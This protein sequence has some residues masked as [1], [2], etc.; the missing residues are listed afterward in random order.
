VPDDLLEGF[1]RD[2]GHSAVLLDIDGTLAPI[3]LHPDDASVPAETIEVLTRLVGRFAL[4]ACVS[5]RPAAEAQRLVPVPGIAFSGNHGLEIA[6]GDA[7]LTVPDAEPYVPTMAALV[8]RLA[9]VAAATGAWIE[10]KGVT[11]AVHYRQ[12]PDPE[13]AEAYLRVEALPLVAEHGLS[14]RFGRMVLEVRPPVPIDKGTA[15]RRLLHGRRIVRSLFAG[16]DTTDLDA[17][18]EV[19]VAIAVVSPEAPP[20]LADAAP[21]VVDGPLGAREL[22]ASLLDEE[23]ARAPQAV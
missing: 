9:P 16:D 7:I 1:R 12:A 19:D 15:V 6:E 2:P 4:V 22:L 5:G 23:P 17:F 8:R 11:L 3:T 21:I 20:G 13:E 14:A 18:A 10:D